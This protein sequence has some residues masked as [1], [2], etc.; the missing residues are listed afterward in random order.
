MEAAA[1]GARGRGFLLD[2]RIGISSRPQWGCEGIYIIIDRHGDG[3]PDHQG[4]GVF[5]RAG[6]ADQDTNP[7]EWSI[8]AGIGGRGIIPSRDN[9]TFGVGYYY[10]RFQTLRVSGIAGLRGEA[11]GFEAY[12]NIAITPAASLTIDV[13]VVE[14]PAA[15]IDA[16]VLRGMRLGLRF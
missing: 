12:Y 2:S 9:D 14:S 5:A 1:S 6:V 13:Q 10:T 7:V 11:Q 16:A 15:D 8:S 4:I 3:V